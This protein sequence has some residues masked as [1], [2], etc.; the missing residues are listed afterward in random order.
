MRYCVLNLYWKKRL[1][2][3]TCPLQTYGQNPIGKL[4]SHLSQSSSLR[5]G[6]FG[7]RERL[8]ALQSGQIGAFRWIC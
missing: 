4:T 8:L 2:T 1:A 3:I 7:L 6:F 5:F